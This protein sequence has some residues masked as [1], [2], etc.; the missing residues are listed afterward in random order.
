MVGDHQNEVI[1]IDYSIRG[2]RRKWTGPSTLP[3]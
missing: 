2:L 3:S 1:E